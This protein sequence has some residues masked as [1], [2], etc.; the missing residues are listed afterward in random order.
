MVKDKFG[1][2]KDFVGVTLRLVLCE[3]QVFY[4]YHS[5]VSLC[6]LQCGDRLSVLMFHVLL[7]TPT[8]LVFFFPLIVCPL[9]R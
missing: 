7:H 6:G 2:R 9:Q 5:C 8:R 3:K 1:L 4:A